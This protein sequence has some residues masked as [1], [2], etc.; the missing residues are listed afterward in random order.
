MEK[1]S[2]ASGRFMPLGT[3]RLALSFAA[4]MMMT[5]PVAAQ[6]GFSWRSYAE[7]G[8]GI[9]VTGGEL[10]PLVAL[11]SGIFIGAVELGSYIQVLPLEF[12]SPDL[13]EA[14]AVA[15]GGSVGY[16]LDTGDNFMQPFGRIGLGGVYTV[17][18]DADGG[19]SGIGSDKKF[20]GVLTLGVALPMSERWSA[21]LWGSY[22][23]T[24]NAVDFEGE[25]LSGFNLGASI[26]ANWTTT[27]R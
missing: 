19:L 4:A 11:E 23:L 1:Q 22:R 5:V 14:A 10:R 18:A 17:E 7:V 27:I 24:D 21:R 6:D 2:Q 3:A 13:V 25:P 15:Y 12:G 16:T 26:R 20:S 8:G 9:S